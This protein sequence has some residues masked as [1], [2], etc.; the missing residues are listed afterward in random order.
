MDTKHAGRASS[1][2]KRKSVVNGYKGL[3]PW[4]SYIPASRFFRESEEVC[5]VSS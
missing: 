4:S 2:F 3:D 1:F 5:D